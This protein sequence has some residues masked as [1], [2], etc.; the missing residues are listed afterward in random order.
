MDEKALLL[1][2]IEDLVFHGMVEGQSLLTLHNLFQSYEQGC[3]CVEEMQGKI[4]SFRS[5]FYLRVMHDNS[6]AY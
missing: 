4:D 2:Q 5:E 1:E 3:I 6:Q